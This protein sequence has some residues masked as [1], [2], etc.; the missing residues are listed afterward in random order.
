VEFSHPHFVV[1]LDPLMSPPGLR[2][3]YDAGAAL[4][5]H[6][7]RLKCFVSLLVLDNSCPESTPSSQRQHS[8]N[9]LLPGNSFFLPPRMLFPCHEFTTKKPPAPALLLRH[10][11]PQQTAVFFGPVSSK[12]GTSPRHFFVAP[13]GTAVLPFFCYPESLLRQCRRARLEYGGSSF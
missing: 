3:S 9:H 10:A 12:L 4:P 13:Y 11:L 7:L 5:R 2:T 1:S 8:I 6:P